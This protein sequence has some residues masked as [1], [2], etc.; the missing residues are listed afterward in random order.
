MPCPNP[1]CKNG[2]IRLLRPL[3][4]V[5]AHLRLIITYA[6]PCLDCL[7]GVTSC[8]DGAGSAQPELQRGDDPGG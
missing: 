5:D 6:I 1:R 4:T 3:F 2:L 8:C 7:G